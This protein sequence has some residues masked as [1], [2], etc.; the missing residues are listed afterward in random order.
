M[1]LAYTIEPLLAVALNDRSKFP[2]FSFW[3]M[4]KEKLELQPKLGTLTPADDAETLNFGDGAKLGVWSFAAKKMMHNQFTRYY[5]TLITSC[6][7]IFMIWS[8]TR[9]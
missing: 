2:K 6:T 8:Q 4:G 9:K 7:Y 5:I 3:V 1:Q